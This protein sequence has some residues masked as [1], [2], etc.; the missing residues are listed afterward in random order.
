MAEKDDLAGPV[1]T[2][3]VAVRLGAQHA[4]I[5]QQQHGVGRR[6]R[7]MPAEK[8]QAG[9]EAQRMRA[10]YLQSYTPA[11]FDAAAIDQQFRG[12][13]PSA[14]DPHLAE[15]VDQI[16]LTVAA[17]AGMPRG[18]VGQDGD[19]GGTRTLGPPDSP[20]W[21][22]MSSSAKQTQY[23]PTAST[24]SMNRSASLALLW[25]MVSTLW[26]WRANG[27]MVTGKGNGGRDST[28][29]SV[30]S[31]RTQYSVRGTFL[32]LLRTGYSVLITSFPPSPPS[33][34]SW[35]PASCR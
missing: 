22:T 29:Y 17:D 8:I 19:V 33:S 20:G 25:A 35:C 2:H 5:G 34:P 28:Q 1:A 11:D 15:G 30:L 18:N 31:T 3:D 14:A 9:R 23:P 7:A 6:L 12:I 10:T 4:R 32:S 13:D 24:Q 26:M 27:N 16:A 21:P